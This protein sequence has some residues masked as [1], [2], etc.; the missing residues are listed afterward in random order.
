MYMYVIIIAVYCG[1]T[2][3]KEE[4]MTLST[5]LASVIVA[6]RF[7]AFWASNAGFSV[8][9]SFTERASH[10][11][12]ELENHLGSSFGIVVSTSS[13]RKPK[14]RIAAAIRE[15]FLQVFALF[16][17]SLSISC[18]PHATRKSKCKFFVWADVRFL[19]F[20]NTYIPFRAAMFSRFITNP[21]GH[22]L[23]FHFIDIIRTNLSI[24]STPDFFSLCRSTVSGFVPGSWCPT[25]E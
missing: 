20:L 6:H 14:E 5:F 21:Y 13:G 8:L 25:F 2:K 16:R 17:T 22:L 23:H 18:I 1:V 19:V 15:I 12:W 10:C 3:N 9:L 7:V 11:R 4:S 24:L